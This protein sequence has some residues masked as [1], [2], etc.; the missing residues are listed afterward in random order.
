MIITALKKI[1]G[2]LLDSILNEI[3]NTHEMITFRKQ[4][5]CDD[6][7]INYRLDLDLPINESDTPISLKIPHDSV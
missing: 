7:K 3:E 1:D 2:K 6:Y 4:G 5:S